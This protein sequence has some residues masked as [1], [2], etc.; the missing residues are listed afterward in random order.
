MLFPALT[1][2]EPQLRSNLSPDYG[3]NVLLQ[4]VIHIRIV[5]RV[6]V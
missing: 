1:A 4:G 3:P 6:R 2:M 5:E